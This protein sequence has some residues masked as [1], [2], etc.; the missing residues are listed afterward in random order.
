MTNASVEF[1]PAYKY[2]IGPSHKGH[3]LERILP[4]TCIKDTIFLQQVLW[5][6]VMFPLTKGQPSNKDRIILAE[7]VS[8]L[9]GDYCIQVLEASDSHLTIRPLMSIGMLLTLSYSSNKALASTKCLSFSSWK[10]INSFNHASLLTRKYRPRY[11]TYTM[12]YSPRLACSKILKSK[13]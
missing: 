13:F 2:T 7:G 6:Y 9:E 10:Q 1:T 4:I 5:M 8:L 3:S 11:L 12:I